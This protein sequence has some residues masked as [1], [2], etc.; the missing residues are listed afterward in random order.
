[1]FFYTRSNKPTLIFIQ[2]TE[3]MSARKFYYHM[4]TTNDD[5][6]KI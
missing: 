2:C 5:F 1:M 4:N 3:F 6:F